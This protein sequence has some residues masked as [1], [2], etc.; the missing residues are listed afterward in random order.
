D[1]RGEFHLGGHPVPGVERIGMERFRIERIRLEAGR[2]VF[3]PRIPQRFILPGIHGILVI[4][5]IGIR[6][7]G[8]PGTLGTLLRIALL[9]LALLEFTLLLTALAAASA[10]A[11]TTAAATTPAPFAR[12]PGALSALLRRTWRPFGGR[13][14]PGGD[15]L[16]LPC[17]PRIAFIA[18]IAATVPIITL[19]RAPLWGTASAAPL[20]IAS[21][22]IAA[23]CIATSY[24]AP[25]IAS[26]RIT[27]LGNNP[28][29]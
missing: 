4:R 10:T 2:L 22:R 12:F 18:F 25:C 5:L 1:G 14:G 26:A 16:C 7:I 24:I 8:R 13:A 6:H 20:R 17:I 11:A 27:P 29:P 21:L 23:P 3:I 28:L 9:D 19:L 15:F